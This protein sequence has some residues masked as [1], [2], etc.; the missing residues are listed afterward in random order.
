[1]VII[2]VHTPETAEYIKK[3][4][5]NACMLYRVSPDGRLL[6]AKT[7][8]PFPG[9]I[10][11]VFLAPAAIHAGDI[12]A[13]YRDNGFTGIMLDAQSPSG[14]LS[15]TASALSEHVP[16]YVPEKLCPDAKNCNILVETAISSGSLRNRFENAISR[17]GRGRVFADIERTRWDFP[18]PFRQER[19][20]PL[21]GEEL[22][23]L[24][25]RRASGPHYSPDLCAWYFSCRE[26]A[27]SRFV[28]YDDAVSINRKLKILSSLG[29]AGAFLNYREVAD[30][31]G[32]IE[33]N[34]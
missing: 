11:G 31:Y 15:E 32:A 12:L 10:M 14:S 2:T 4:E 24:F 6:R 19:G 28:L 3:T 9:I 8:E 21:S 34:Y 30:I 16:V 25:R 18:L 26:N 27:G 17:Y 33:K 20:R 22:K 1:M 5:N 13:E 29:I 23:A 7:E